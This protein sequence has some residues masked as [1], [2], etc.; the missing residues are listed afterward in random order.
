[1]QEPTDSD[2]AIP[3]RSEVA[4]ER[5]IKRIGHTFH[6]PFCVLAGTF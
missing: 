3:R 6:S 5:M 2:I 1:M 4:R